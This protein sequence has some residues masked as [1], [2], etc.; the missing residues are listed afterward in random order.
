M[1]DRVFETAGRYGGTA[2]YEYLGFRR[3]FAGLERDTRRCARALRALGIRPRDRVTV[4]LPNI[5]QAVILFYALNA[6]GAVAC[7]THPLSSAEEMSFYLSSAKPRA[8]F[9]MYG[10]YE[11]FRPALARQDGALRVVLTG[12][13]DALPPIPAAA[14]SVAEKKPPRG[15]DVLRWREFLRFAE[16]SPAGTPGEKPDSGDTAAILYSG[17]TSG[18]TKGILLTNGSFNALADMTARASGSIVPGKKMLAV[19]PVFHGFGLGVCIHTALA[20]GVTCLLVPRFT[21]KTYAALLKT[22]RPNYIAGVPTLFEALLR[23]ENTERLDLSDLDGVFSGGDTMTP[24]LRA[25]VDEFLRAR[26]SPS[27]VRE[28]YGLTECV[29]VCCLTPEGAGGTEPG[30]IGKPLDGMAM[31]ITE[32]GTERELCAEETG[33]ICVSGP[34]VMAG[35]DGDEEETREALRTHGDGRVWLHTGDL[36]EIGADG[37]VYFRGR[38]KRLI[39]SSGYSV[40]PYHVESVLCGHEFV[41]RCCV[42]GVPDEYKMQRVKAYIV[43]KKGAPPEVEAIESVKAYCRASLAPYNRPRE[44]EVRDSLPATALGKVAYRELEREAAERKNA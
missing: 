26:G 25:R 6:I 31:K 39:V 20:C 16:R 38:I 2:A 42:V 10:F 21:V 11:K 13:G 19:M 12:A 36:G 7:M 33:E 8:F 9:T 27:R 29:T 43:L 18:K 30:C 37:Y 14:M 5:P 24:G 40:Y 3:S 34:T 35:Y 23:L 4:S 1:A 41:E 44:Y 17:G 15:G 22:R 32:R 28:G